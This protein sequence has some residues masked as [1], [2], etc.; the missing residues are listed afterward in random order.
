M[1]VQKEDRRRIKAFAC[2]LLLGQS[3]NPFGMEY[4][5][6]T[7]VEIAENMVRLAYVESI[8]Y[9]HGI[10]MF[11]LNNLTADDA[12]KLNQYVATLPHNHT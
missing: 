10:H 11:C 9:G 7:S 12:V 5:K 6:L 8:A 3:G 4:P 1:E 2:D